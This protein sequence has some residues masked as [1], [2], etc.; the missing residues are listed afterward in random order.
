M[1]RPPTPPTPARRPDWEFPVAGAKAVRRLAD[2]VRELRER[3]AHGNRR[4]FFDDVFVAHLLAFF[5]PGLRSLRKL[6]DFSQTRQAQRHL[7]APRLTRSALSDY[8]RLADA[9]RL[10]P[11]LEALRGELDRG[12]PPQI[13]TPTGRPADGDLLALL[14]RVEARDGT[15][16]SVAADVAWAIGKRRPAVRG[17]PAAKG[18]QV[19]VDVSLHAGS[20]IPEVVAVHGAEASEAEQAAEIVRPGAVYLYDRGILSFDL[21]EKQL[22]AGADF[23]HR[24]RTP[25]E[26]TPRLTPTEER[27]LSDDDRRAGIV[28]DRLGTLAGSQHR[29]PPTA[30]LREVVVACPDDPEAEMRLLTSLLDVPAWVV[31]LL[32]RWRW[33]IELFFRWLKVYAGFDHL[34][35]HSKA[36]VE[37]AVYTAV[38]GTLLVCLQ[39]GGR[40]S[41]HAFALLGLVAQG[42]ATLEEIAPILR[43]RERQ[44]ALDRAGQARRAAA[45]KSA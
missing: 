3:D 36:G 2:F 18:R 35:S 43:E 21:L 5:N 14:R 28:A 41:T 16:L 38:I 26:R 15:F 31:A 24:L 13:V 23:V 32:Y 17:A 9:E 39:S 7:A 37:V 44:S 40:P 33:Q 29:T 34:V 4:V 20:W 30:T 8:H 42:Q 22:G 27:P 19:R 1:R 10:Q 45:K 25:G 11:L 6:E 12:L